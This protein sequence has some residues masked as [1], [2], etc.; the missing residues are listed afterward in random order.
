MKPNKNLQF[1]LNGQE[2]IELNQLLKVLS[3]VNSGGEAN[4]L[5]SDG[6]VLVN[7]QVETRKRNKIRGG[8]K[9]VF[10]GYTIHVFA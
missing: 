5:I 1:D 6:R 7:G 9:V 3:L 2:Y 8:F 4:I 10:E